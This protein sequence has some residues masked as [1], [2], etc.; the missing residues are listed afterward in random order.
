MDTGNEVYNALLITLPSCIKWEDYEKEL[1]LAE[2]ESQ[3]M[4][5]KV[6]FLP[7][8]TKNIE[9]VYLI[10]LGYIVGWQKFIGVDI[11]K[12]KCT[13]TGTEWNGKFIQRTGKFH[14]IDPIPHKGF[15]GFR[16][17]KF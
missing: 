9:R 3:I 12:F 16:Y 7:K 6:P 8:C 17:Y 4:N 15:R 13:T 10:H 2:D 11:K 14:K 5:F 1:R